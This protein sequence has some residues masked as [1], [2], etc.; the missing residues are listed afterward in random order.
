MTLRWFALCGFLVLLTGCSN[1]WTKPGASQQAFGADRSACLDEAQRPG[2]P[3]YVNPFTG[4]FEQQGHT[5]RRVF[6]ACMVEH[7]WSKSDG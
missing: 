7:G 6:D 4:F 1:P 2:G 3:V 5:D